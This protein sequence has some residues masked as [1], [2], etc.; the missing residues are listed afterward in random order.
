MSKLRRGVP[1]ARE[2]KATGFPGPGKATSRAPAGYLSG[3]SGLLRRIADRIDHANAPRITNWT[4]T[5]ERG[6]GV[7]FREDGR[8][9]PIGYFPEF[10]DRAHTE[11]DKPC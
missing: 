11:A 10:Y 6:E 1:W 9:C 2:P 8:G 3:F 7:R 5:F 4:F